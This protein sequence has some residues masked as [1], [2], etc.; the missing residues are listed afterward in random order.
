MESSPH[1][2][3]VPCFRCKKMTQIKCEPGGAFQQ[4][5]MQTVICKSCGGSFEQDFPGKLIR[6]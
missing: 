6:D 1:I 3:E 4:T 2:V 5:S